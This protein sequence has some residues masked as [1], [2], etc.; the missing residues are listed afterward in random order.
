MKLSI[1]VPVLNEARNLVEMMP[2]F[3][4]HK[5]RNKFEV[6]VVDGGSEDE[7]FQ[8]AKNLGV[9]IIQSKERLWKISILS[10][11]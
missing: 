4:N 11:G 8:I 9:R 3:L 7:S 10:E 2:F 5:Q 1:I 6:I